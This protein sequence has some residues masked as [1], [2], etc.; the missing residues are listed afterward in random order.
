MKQ[1][2]PPKKCVVVVEDDKGLREQLVELLGSAEDIRCGGAFSTGKE[3]LREIPSLHPEVVLMDIRLPDLSGIQCVSEL[4]KV[5]PALEIVMVTIYA[6]SERIFKALKAGASGYLLK[7][8]PPEGLIEAIRDVSRG[9]APISSQ[10][11]RKVIQHSRV[12]GPSQSNAKQLSPREEQ[13]LT[14]LSTGAVY[15]EIAAELGISLETVRTYVKI[16]CR[17][18]HARNR[19][20]AVVKRLSGVD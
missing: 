15:K 10:I 3:A 11:A 7:S 17:K 20:E 5:M 16:I 9:G 13:V 2:K 12:I 8:G 19:L 4:K 1:S 18:M 14:M 6:D